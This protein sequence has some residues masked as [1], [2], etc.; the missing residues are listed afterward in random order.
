MMN[1]SYSGEIR[2][3]PVPHYHLLRSRR[4]IPPF[5]RLQPADYIVAGDGILMR[6]PYMG[7]LMDFPVVGCAIRG[8]APWATW[9][10]GVV[11][12]SGAGEEDDEPSV[13]QPFT[14]LYH[15][16]RKGWPLPPLDPRRM[17]EYA[18]A[19]NGVFLRAERYGIEVL[20]PVSPPCELVGLAQ[21]SQSIRLSFPRIGPE[22]LTGM[23]ERARAQT[24]DG[25]Q[26]DERLF[27]LLLREG[28]W[29]VFEPEQEQRE[30]RV[31]PRDRQLAARLGVFAEA[32]SHHTMPAFFSETDDDDERWSGFYAVLGRITTEPEVCLR[33]VVDDY[34]WRCPAGVLFDLPPGV[35][36]TLLKAPGALLERS[37]EQW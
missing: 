8:L 36:D 11:G 5:D 14:P 24:Q 13:E 23:F 16:V 1:T 4:R 26:F 6:V 10:E 17:Y 30:G 34:R 28:R 27:Y 3:S 9:C 21:L 7:M 32:H 19:G 25:V 31:K 33:L 20:M 12:A 37:V 35:H 18:V 2:V 15:L 22:L 29:E